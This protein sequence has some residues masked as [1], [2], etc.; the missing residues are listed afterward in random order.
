VMKCARFSAFGLTAN[1]G[2]RLPARACRI[3][4]NSPDRANA[5]CFANAASP[6]PMNT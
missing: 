4:L 1:A 6:G 3:Q 2:I 5:L